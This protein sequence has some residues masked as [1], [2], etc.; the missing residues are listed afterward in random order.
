MSEE[1]KI[2]PLMRNGVEVKL[3]NPGTE[4]LKDFL[5]LAKAMSKV[6]QDKP[7]MFL[8]CLDDKA[9]DSAIKLIKLSV[10]K[11]YPEFTDDDDEWAMENAMMILPK[12]IEMCSPKQDRNTSRVQELKDKIDAQSVKS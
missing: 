8:E 12:V 4:G 6:P 5:I 1:Q 3:K 7:E 2:E 11:T 10:K 9:M